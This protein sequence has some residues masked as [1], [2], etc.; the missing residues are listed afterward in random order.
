VTRSTYDLI[1]TVLLVLMAGAPLGVWALAVGRRVRVRWAWGSFGLCF[2]LWVGLSFYQLV[3]Q[4]RVGQDEV[5]GLS[6]TFKGR[7]KSDGPAP[8]GKTNMPARGEALAWVG[9]GA[10]G[11]LFLGYPVRIPKLS[12][13]FK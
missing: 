10:A 3:L 12:H 5:A 11:E 7:V 4:V 8:Y 2:C 9:A 6:A 13:T 1:G